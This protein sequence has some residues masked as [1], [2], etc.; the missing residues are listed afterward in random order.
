[1][2]PTWLFAEPS[3]GHGDSNKMSCRSRG[4]IV[5]E[6]AGTIHLSPP[7][8]ASF[9]RKQW[10]AHRVQRLS[11]KGSLPYQVLPFRGW[12]RHVSAPASWLI[13]TGMKECTRRLIAA[14]S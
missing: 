12:F 3:G 13:R 9:Y 1:M 14:A 7:D 2:V 11:V 8:C 4:L 6:L 10:T 5:K